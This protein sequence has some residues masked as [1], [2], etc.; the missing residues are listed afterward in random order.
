MPRGRTRDAGQPGLDE[1]RTDLVRATVL[2]LFPEMFPGPLG[3]SLAGPGAGARRLVARRARHPRARPRPASRRRRHAGRRRAGHGDARRRAGRA[4]STRFARRTIPPAPADEPAR[5]AARRRPACATSRRAPASSS[6][7]AGSRAS[8]S[9]V[10]D[11][12]GLEEVS[13]GDYVLSGGELAALVADRR[14]RAAAARRHGQARLRRRRKLRERAARISALHP[15]ASVR[16]G[17]SPRSCSPATTRSR[18]LAAR[19]GRA[20]HARA[21]A[22]PVARRGRRLSRKDRQKTRRDG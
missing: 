4:P 21:A 3:L 1:L 10:I 22:G 19:R 11:G 12:R 7:A 8:T 9:G 2:T 14:L 6:S 16:A 17:R 5:Q 13:I 20:A 18:R 15:P